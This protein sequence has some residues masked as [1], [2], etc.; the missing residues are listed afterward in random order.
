MQ[1]IGDPD[2]TE[3]ERGPLNLVL[4]FGASLEDVGVKGIG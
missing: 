3:F 2:K 4:A 1:R